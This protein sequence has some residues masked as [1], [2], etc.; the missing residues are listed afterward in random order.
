MQCSSCIISI[1][2]IMDI[3]MIHHH[4]NSTS[5]SV[6]IRKMVHVINNAKTRE[7]ETNKGD[8][9]GRE[10]KETGF[11]IIENQ[12]ERVVVRVGS[13]Y[14]ASRKRRPAMVPS[15]VTGTLITIRRRSMDAKARPVAYRA[16]AVVPHV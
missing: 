11:R 16:S 8:G 7:M 2:I 3:S 14:P 1:D 5:N 4:R 13:T 6:S 15:L 9:G 12:N 10:Q